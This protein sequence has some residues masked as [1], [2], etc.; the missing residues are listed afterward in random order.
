MRK[1]AALVGTVLVLSVIAPHPA[2]AE[3]F[4]VTA[5]SIFGF[6]PDGDV[7]HFT[8]A[9][10]DIRPDPSVSF[11]IQAVA[12]GGCLGDNP[13]GSPFN[14]TQGDVIDMSVRTVGE[15]SMG[16]GTATLNGT[17][18][19]DVAFFGDLTFTANQSPFPAIADHLVIFNQSFLFNGALR[20]VVGGEEVF[21]IDLTGT[22][23]TSRTFF[24]NADGTYNYQMESLTSFVFDAAPPPP[25]AP[26]PEPSSVLL[27]GSGLAALA[28]R[29]RRRRH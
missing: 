21:N 23:Q 12:G 2:Q 17:T 14:C 18:Y 16:T 7:F 10:F 13:A 6:A 28:A 24:R 5:P 15:V 3:P 4:V 8:G 11:A 20:G 22:G 1:F 25:P 26:T 19:S 29:A 9:G 27:L